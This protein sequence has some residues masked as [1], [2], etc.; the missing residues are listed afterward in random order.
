[1]LLLASALVGLIAA[2]WRRL[3]KRIRRVEPP[4]GKARE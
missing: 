3:G 4:G 1:M 2:G